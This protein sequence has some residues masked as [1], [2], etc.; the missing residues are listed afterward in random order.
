MILSIT[1]FSHSILIYH[2][3]TIC[4]ISIFQCFFSRFATN[5]Y[6][7]S[8]FDGH[9]DSFYR[10]RVLFVLQI[11]LSSIMEESLSHLLRSRRP[12]SRSYSDMC[13]PR[14]KIRNHSCGNHSFLKMNNNEKLFKKL[15][16]ISYPI[17]L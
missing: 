11:L 13:H 9:F 10:K 8:F 12:G 2:L 3:K 6:W 5:F 15:V 4:S 7:W 16:L 17:N 1:F 14:Y